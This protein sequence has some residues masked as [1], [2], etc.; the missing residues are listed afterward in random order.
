MSLVE[1]FKTVREFLDLDKNAIAGAITGIFVGGAATFWYFRKKIRPLL[2]LL[3]ENEELENEL[4]KVCREVV[5]LR[6]ECRRAG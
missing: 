2:E 3:R 5:R 4:L 6:A 1:T